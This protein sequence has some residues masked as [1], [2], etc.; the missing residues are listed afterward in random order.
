MPVCL[1]EPSRFYKARGGGHRG[2]DGECKGPA[3]DP[4][5][6]HGSAQH[7]PLALAERQGSLGKVWFPSEAARLG[8]EGASVDDLDD[9]DKMTLF[10]WSFS[11]PTPAAYGGS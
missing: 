8:P 2:A 10:F 9:S 7:Q 6:S 3:G 1:G 4:A 5:L 11:K